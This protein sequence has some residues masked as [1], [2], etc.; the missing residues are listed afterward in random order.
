VK[1]L[2][3]SQDPFL[4]QAAVEV[5]AQLEGKDPPPA[6]EHPWAKS[7]AALEALPAGTRFL[8]DL[9]M[10]SAAGIL[11][12]A[13]RIDAFIKNFTTQMAGMGMPADEGDRML[14][15]ATKGILTFA[16][17]CGNVSLDRIDVAN[18]GSVGDSGGGMAIIF[19]GQYEPGLLA[20]GLPE[21]GGFTAEEVSGLKVLS[22]GKNGPRLVLLDEHHI[23][24][25]FPGEPSNHFPLDAYLQAFKA[26]SKPLA[27]E[28]RWA[29]FLKTLETGGMRALAVTDET[30]MTEL[31][32]ELEREV[33]PDVLAAVKGMQ[34]IEAEVKAADSKKLAYRF[35]AAFAEA[36][37]AS[38]MADTMKGLIAQGVAELEQNAAQFSGSPIEDMMKK[39][40]EVLKSVKVVGEG[41]K[42]ILRGELDPSLLFSGF[43]G[44]S[45][46]H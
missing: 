43:F 44:V 40:Q 29:K 18:V 33:T 41:K 4:K 5:L 39:L 27:G 9:P 1:E 20:R 6:P 11:G 32:G 37:Q 7:L 46:M 30:L 24:L 10:T 14:R 15:E 8:V 21:M 45:V 34:E 3:S 22:S 17:K 23:L 35:E 36:K 26:R 19:C 42:G 16:E 31:Y 28:A 12:G 38:D 25:L 13:P 2:V